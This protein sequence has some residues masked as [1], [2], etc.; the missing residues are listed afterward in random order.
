MGRIPN[1]HCGVKYEIEVQVSD[2]RAIQDRKFYAYWYCLTY[3]ERHGAPCSG[4]SSGGFRSERLAVA[5]VEVEFVHH[6][7]FAH[8]PGARMGLDH[9]LTR[10]AHERERKQLVEELRKAGQLA[11]KTADEKANLEHLMKHDL[12]PNFSA[13]APNPPNP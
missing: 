6:Y 11:R 9:K 13:P 2:S 12:L 7:E 5:Q 4:G 8:G 1:E 10:D 3:A